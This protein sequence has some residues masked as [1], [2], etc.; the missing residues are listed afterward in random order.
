MTEHRDDGHSPEASCSPAGVADSL[1]TNELWPE[2]TP[3]LWDEIAELPPT[4]T[5]RDRE[6]RAI[7]DWVAR[8]NATVA[9]HGF[10]PIRM[11]DP[12]DE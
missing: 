2:S 1:V 6:R 5:E 9:E 3:G 10:A 11:I 8:H 4:E 12:D 7:G